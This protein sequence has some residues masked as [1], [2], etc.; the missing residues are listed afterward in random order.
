MMASEL[1]N[2]I[3]FLLLLVW[4]PTIQGAPSQIT[5]IDQAVGLVT[6]NANWSVDPCDN[7]Y[8]FACS[9]NS[10][11]MD[12]TAQMMIETKSS[13][14]LRDFKT[15]PSNT[16]TLTNLRAF[17]TSCLRRGELQPMIMLTSI[18]DLL[19]YRIIRQARS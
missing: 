5:K 14:L 1:V 11:S 16:E 2:Y 17:L 19:T 10:L 4:T 12:Y 18:F 15:Y 3:T 7:F 6:K 13:N 8:S 9:R